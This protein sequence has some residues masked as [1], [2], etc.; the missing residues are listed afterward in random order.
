MHFGTTLRLLRVDAGI[1]LRGLAHRVG[2]SS[3]YLSRVEN[4]VDPAPTPER[5]TAIADALDVSPTL[6]LDV[7]HQVGPVV[8]EYLERV[9]TANALFLDIARRDLGAQDIAKLR[10]YLDREFPD[11]SAAPPATSL[12][13]LLA[14]ERVLLRFRGDFAAIVTAAAARLVPGAAARTTLAARIREREAESPTALG[15][16]L[17]VPH[18]I[19]PGAAASAVLVTTADPLRHETPDGVPLRVIVVLVS[20]EGGHAHLERLAHVAQLAS[21]GLIETLT[22]A[23]TTHEALGVVATVHEK[24]GHETRQ[25]RP[26]RAKKG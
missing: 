4:G 13:D 15:D 7:A 22:K 9:P 18:A 8:T 14:P 20:G 16:G 6:L 2:V 19:V 1:S 26:R 11:R 17:A 23:R 10:A 3:T 5:L 21:H 12:H 25:G 24:N